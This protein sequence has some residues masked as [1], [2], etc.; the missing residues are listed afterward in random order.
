MPQIVALG[1][2]DRRVRD[3]PAI[4]RSRRGPRP[5]S[6]PTRPRH[7]CRAGF[8]RWRCRH[9]W[10]LLSPGGIAVKLGDH[11]RKRRLVQ[12][13]RTHGVQRDII[14][15]SPA[16]ASKIEVD[17]RQ[18]DSRGPRGARSARA[19]HRRTIP[20]CIRRSRAN[21]LGLRSEIMRRQAAAVAC[22]FAG[23]GQRQLVE[24]FPRHD[25]GRRLEMARSASSRRSACV[26]RFG[27][28]SDSSASPSRL[29]IWVSILIGQSTSILVSYRGAITLADRSANATEVPHESAL[30][31]RTRTVPLD[32]P[33]F[34][35]E[36]DRALPRAVGKARRRRPRGL[37]QGR[38]QRAC[39]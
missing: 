14:S 7:R 2:Y 1:L 31:A 18:S 26:R 12:R 22:G 17:R 30:H 8:R 28:E 33:P 16:Q 36:G 29:D 23:I 34:H 24:T 9:E 11:G 15:R 35:R 6:A 3:R 32:G 5:G 25:P 39:C 20:G 19:N 21:K 38:R 27:T 13:A 4:A 37:A 10:R